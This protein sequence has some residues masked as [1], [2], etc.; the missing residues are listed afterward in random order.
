LWKECGV[1]K[2]CGVGL[3][4]EWMLELQM[5]LGKKREEDGLGGGLYTRPQAYHEA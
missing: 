3:I 4:N 2:D 1:G 5:V